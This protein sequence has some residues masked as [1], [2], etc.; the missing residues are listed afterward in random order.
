[1][2]EPQS[3]S[4]SQIRQHCLECCGDSAPAVTWCT[5][6]GLNS[7]PCRLWPYR[8]GRQPETFRR[9]YGPWLLVP[10]SMP[11]VDIEL[12]TLP[13]KL[14]DTIQ[15]FR[16]HHPEVEWDGPQEST[17]T[18]ERREIALRGLAKARALQQQATIVVKHGRQR[19]VPPPSRA[20]Q[21]R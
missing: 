5:C 19:A 14:A 20:I 10:Q 16:E 8:F 3:P 11:G 6:D 12:E 13:G 7:T 18:P 1:M 2:G 17:L 21:P 4:L 15:W 9:K